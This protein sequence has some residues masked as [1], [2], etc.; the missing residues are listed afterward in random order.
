[1]ADGK[2]KL[3][4]SSYEELVKIVRGYAHQ[5]K[6][7]LLSEIAKVT[8]MA[9]TRISANNSFLIGI[10]LI[11]DGKAKIA[12][13]IGKDLGKAIEHGMSD[14]ISNIWGKIVKSNDFLSKMIAAVTIRNGMEIGSLEAHI[15]Y[16]A[17]EAKASY[18][19]TG[20]RAVIEILKASGLVIVDGGKIV[21]AQKNSEQLIDLKENSVICSTSSSVEPPILPM[22]EASQIISK[23]TRSGININI[24]VR[25]TASVDEMDTLSI[26]LKDLIGVL[27][28]NPNINEG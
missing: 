17:G 5:E 6:P 27:D 9:E 15:A 8:G 4:R 14:E 26:K 24:E 12:T 18:V 20:A 10:G 22:R 3:P 7:V 19:E 23:T 21:A 11:E 28:N 25:I 13:P 2:I 16:S 1:M